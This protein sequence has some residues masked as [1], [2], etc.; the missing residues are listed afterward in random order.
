MRKDTLKRYSIISMYKRV[1]GKSIFL[2][3]E[4]YQ[5]NSSK[6]YLLGN[7]GERDTC[8]KSKVVK[9]GNKKRLSDH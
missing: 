4:I 2:W 3:N 5:L 6:R 9:Q 7:M 8:K 1:W